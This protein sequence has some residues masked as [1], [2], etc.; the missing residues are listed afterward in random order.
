MVN[1]FFVQHFLLTKIGIKISKHFNQ[2]L[3]VTLSV[4]KYQIYSASGVNEK[5]KTSTDKISLN[6]LSSLALGWVFEE[7]KITSSTNA[8]VD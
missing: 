2:R 5:I 6:N 1:N 8:V 7:V 4:L 3:Y